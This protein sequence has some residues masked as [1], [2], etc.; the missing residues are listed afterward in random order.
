MVIPDKK[1]KE[2][3]AGAKET[4]LTRT[5]IPH[6]ELTPTQSVNV[7]ASPLAATPT[8]TKQVSLVISKCVPCRQRSMHA[9]FS[10]SVLINSWS[11]RYLKYYCCSSSKIDVYNCIYCFRKRNRKN[12]HFPPSPLK[13]YHC[14]FT[15]LYFFPNSQLLQSRSSSHR[16]NWIQSSTRNQQQNRRYFAVLFSFSATLGS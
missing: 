4:V 15:F 14:T 2:D 13:L 5:N 7:L 3:D 11:N 16:T 8:S 6:A 9:F 12:S 1:R 10:P